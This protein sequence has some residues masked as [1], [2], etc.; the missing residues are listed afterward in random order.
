MSSSKI[1]EDIRILD[2]THVWFGPYCTM[3]LAELGAEVILVEPPWG[4]IGRFGPG[5]LFKGTSTSFYALN[6]NKKGIAVDLKTE[7]GKDIVKELIKTS[8]IVVQNFVPGTLEKLG[9]GYE[10][11]KELNDDIIYAALSGFGQDGP[12]SKYASYAVIAEAVSGHTKAN[13]R[14]VVGDGPPSSLAGA[15]GDIGPATMAAFGIMA[16]LRHRDR[17]GEGQKLD[18]NQVDTMVSF[19]TCSSVGWAMFE[20]SGTPRPE[21]RRRG[22]DPTSVGGMYRVKDGW[23]QL[24]GARAKAMENLKTAL[25]TEDVNK[26]LVNE[27][28]KDMTRREA[29]QYL[30]GLGFPAA[31][32]YEAHESMDDPHLLARNMW[33][34]VPQRV[35]GEYR[36]PNFPVKLYNTPGEPTFGAPQL[37]EHTEDVLV[38]ILGYSTEKVAELEKASKVVCWRK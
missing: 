7:E 14:R 8:D 10:V 36:V 32:V 38:N 22:Q 15:I 16:A 18:V 37:G 28:I 33:K 11:Q 6:L 3:L 17:T 29:F 31:P 34:K 20:D 12:Y 24:M 21:R 2:F 1:L 35:A 23:V 9:L 25:G 13:A 5:A 30:A 19:N 26:D 4:N 27:K